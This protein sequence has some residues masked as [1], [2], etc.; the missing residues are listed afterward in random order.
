MACRKGWCSCTTAVGFEKGIDCDFEH[1][2]HGTRD[3]SH[4]I[5]SY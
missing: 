4:A 2:L 1:V 5:G 3:F